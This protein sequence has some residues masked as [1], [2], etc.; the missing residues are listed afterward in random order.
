MFQICVVVIV[1][2]RTANSE[3][4]FISTDMPGGNMTTHAYLSTHTVYQ[5]KI[6]FLHYFGGIYGHTGK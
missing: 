6:Q 5:Y 2:E 3:A 4:G 1:V